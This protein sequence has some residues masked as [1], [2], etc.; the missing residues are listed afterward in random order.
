MS[1]LNSISEMIVVTTTDTVTIVYPT[2]FLDDV[3]YEIHVGLPITTDVGT[4]G[5]EVTARD[6]FGC[7]V[8]F[9]TAWS[10]YLAYSAKGSIA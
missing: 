1:V 4:G 8:S 2:P 7:T 5:G 9:R 10:G 6:R 3:A